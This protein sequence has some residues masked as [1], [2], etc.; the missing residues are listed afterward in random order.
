MTTKKSIITLLLILISLNIFT[1]SKRLGTESSEQKVKRMEQ[2]THDRFGMFIHFG[3]YS[4][5]ARHEWV[6]KFEK[7]STEDYQKYIDVFNPDLFNPKEWAQKAKDAGMKYAVITAKHHDGFCL[8]DSKHTEYKSIKTAFGRDLV[9]E[10][11]DAFRAQGISVGLYYSLIDWHHPDFTVDKNHPQSPSNQKEYSV[12]NKDRDMNKYRSYLHNQVIELMTNYGKIDILWLDYSYPGENGKDK[13]DWDSEKLIKLV[14]KLQPDILIN[15]RA[16]LKDYED[17]WDFT[18]P[19]QFK[20]AKWPEVNGK[21]VPWETCQ[22]FS[23]SWGYSRDENTWKDTKQLL[24]LLIETVSKGGNLILNVGPTARG[25]FDSRADAALKSMGEWMKY[26]CRSIY[27]CTE[28][29]AE[30]NVPERSLLTYNPLTKRLYV[31]LID[32]PLQNF[33]LPNYKVKVKYAQFLHDGSEVQFAKP[34]GAW[35]NEDVPEND[36]NL[37]LPVKKPDVEIPVIELILK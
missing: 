28:A 17:G 30:F 25:I 9:K 5:A 10:F 13:K 4:S 22:T 12:L 24:T 3:L 14:R 33:K 35:M 26:N 11:I 32:Y 37:I 18:T 21:K 27:G 6:K 8:F 31:H 34:Q 23:G 36:L 7:I 16:D 15:D 2:W 19:E 29:P 1:Q 20:V